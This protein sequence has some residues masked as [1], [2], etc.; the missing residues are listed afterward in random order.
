MVTT[1]RQNGE[2][3]ATLISI[4]YF[5]ENKGCTKT[6]NTMKSFAV[7]SEQAISSNP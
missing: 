7:K 1:S 4:N 5:W 3:K 6:K 2:Y